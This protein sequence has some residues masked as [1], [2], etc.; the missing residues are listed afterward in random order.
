MDSTPH[1]SSAFNSFSTSST[2]HHPRTSS[3]STAGDAN[4]RR[5]NRTSEASR[6]LHSDGEVPTSSSEYHGRVVLEEMGAGGETW[7]DFLRHSP[8]LGQT[9]AEQVRMA[10]ER[11]V[12]I[13]ADRKRRVSEHQED[14]SRRRSVSSISMGQ[15]TNQRMRQSLPQTTHDH[16]LFTNPG[17][18]ESH[19]RQRITDRPLPRRPSLGSS[20]YCR[21]QESTLPRWQPD[22]EVS[23]CPICGAQFGFLNRRHH[24]RKCGRVV[25]AS[26]S[27]HR[28][29]IPRQ[30]IVRPPWE[31]ATTQIARTVA[32]PEV[33]GLT[34]GSE[35]TAASPHRPEQR[36]RP[37]IQDY[38]IDS[39]LGGGQ[40]VRL[41]NPCVPDPNPLPHLAYTPPTRYGVASFTEPG[42]SPQVSNRS[43]PRDLVAPGH[44]GPSLARSISSDSL[45]RQVANFNTSY[46]ATRPSSRDSPLLSGPVIDRRH[47]HA[48]RPLERVSQPPP[49]Y[50]SIFDSAPGP[51][52]DDVSSYVPTA[53]KLLI[54][55]AGVYPISPPTTWAT[56]SS[57]SSSPFHRRRSCASSSSLDV[58]C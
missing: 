51:P 23:T 20:E 33:V 48:S 47:S 42:R 43:S 46:G 54:Q 45:N 31:A 25:C 22:N 21:S 1:D 11:A 13:A 8:A 55:L 12:L 39:A 49:N 6:R 24:C 36:S 17:S 28:I 38:R 32:G 15:I 9:T 10:K 2:S 5:D 52:H 26:C 40:E 7:M 37:P 18:A 58:R 57:P 29:T 16:P 14:Q 41:C 27:P 3:H 56:T 44:Q 35:R 53:S 30:F 4:S 34:S 50:Q 19:F